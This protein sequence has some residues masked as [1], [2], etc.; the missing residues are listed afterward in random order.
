MAISTEINKDMRCKAL[1]G[2]EP[3]YYK[4]FDKIMTDSI[5]L[6]SSNRS[7]FKIVLCLSEFLF[8]YSASN[9]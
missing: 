4:Y 7:D 9:I 2:K 6:S 8:S 5:Y 3:F 1:E